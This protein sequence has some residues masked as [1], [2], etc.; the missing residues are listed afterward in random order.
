M[1]VQLRRLVVE[2]GVTPI[3]SS[4][5]PAIRLIE[6][7]FNLE[8]CRLGHSRRLRPPRRLP[9]GETWC[10]GKVF[11]QMEYSRS[12]F[13][14]KPVEVAGTHVHHPPP[15]APASRLGGAETSIEPEPLHL[16][17]TRAERASQS[18]PR[19]E[20]RR[21]RVPRLSVLLDSRG[22]A[23]EQLQP[24]GP[25]RSKYGVSA[26]SGDGVTPRCC[27]CGSGLKPAGRDSPPGEML[28]LLPRGRP[29]VQLRGWE[30]PPGTHDLRK[31]V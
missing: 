21:S 12:T 4:S 20:H 28:R 2:H 9:M 29:L 22:G 26:V 5:H 24:A 31:I 19:A 15:T 14:Q 6:P 27:I 10:T 1:E 30:L 13:E 8:R 17:S 16:E 25:L 18:G 7:R 23:V 11:V 3:G